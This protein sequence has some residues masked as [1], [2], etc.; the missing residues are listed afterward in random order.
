VKR[1][2]DIATFKKIRALWDGNP[3]ETTIQPSF[4]TT[5]EGCS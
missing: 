1:G 4:S 5:K 2:H 3:L